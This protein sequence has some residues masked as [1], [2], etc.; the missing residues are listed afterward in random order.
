[1]ASRRRKPAAGPSLFGEDPSS[2]AA[3]PAPLSRL[4]QDRQQAISRGDARRAE[5]KSLPLGC[6]PSP[7][8]RVR[9]NAMPG[10]REDGK[11]WFEGPGKAKHSGEGPVHSH[12]DR[13]YRSTSGKPVT[14][15][16]RRGDRWLPWHFDPEFNPN[17]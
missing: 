7:Q 2:P 16:V 14:R 8:E 13:P 1:M 17:G 15:D 3:S 11:L 6:L 10:R 9:H 4:P 12:Y 5:G